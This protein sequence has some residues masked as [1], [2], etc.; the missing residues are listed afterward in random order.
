[1]DFESL[2]TGKPFTN[3]CDCGCDLTNN[4]TSYT[5]QKSYVG[6]ECIF[7]YAICSDCVESIS[8]QFSEKSREAMFDFFHDRADFEEK[9][10]RLG[11]DA[12]I[13]DHI[14]KCFT[15]GT[16]REEATSYSYS[17]HFMGSILLPGIFPVMFCDKCEEE[18][19]ECLSEKTRE[20]WERFLQEHFPG[21][22]ADALDKPRTGKPILL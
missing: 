22:P 10:I 14:E 13:D 17:G 12:T 6:N 19:T 9:L 8:E 20:V 21:P 2:E 16:L 7:E 5:V 15:C 11:P 4:Y 18:L 3:C 1:M